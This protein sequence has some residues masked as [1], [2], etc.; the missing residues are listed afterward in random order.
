[1]YHIGRIHPNETLT[2][3]LAE[4]VVTEQ[5]EAF[6][7]I[8]KIQKLKAIRADFSKLRKTFVEMGLFETNYLF[9]LFHALHITVFQFLG[10][11]I[12][13]NYGCGFVPFCCALTCHIIAQ[14]N[15][16]L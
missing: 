15:C 10:F 2:L 8:D 1:M 3:P 6:T 14:V 7:E 12:L 16:F 11:Y 4:D 9:F 13:W 5:T